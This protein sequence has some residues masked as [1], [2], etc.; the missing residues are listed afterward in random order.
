VA[1]ALDWSASRNLTNYSWSGGALGGRL[2]RARICLERPIPTH[3][4][5]LEKPPL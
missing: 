1:L 3:I 5:S 2:L 4:E